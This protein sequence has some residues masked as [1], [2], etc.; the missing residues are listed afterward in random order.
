MRVRGLGVL[1]GNQPTAE[2]MQ[3]T[4]GKRDLSGWPLPI[5]PARTLPVTA[6]FTATPSSHFSPLTHHHLQFSF[7]SYRHP[8]VPASYIPLQSPPLPRFRLQCLKSSSS[9]STRTSQ[10]TPISTPSTRTVTS[11]L[12]ASINSSPSSTQIPPSLPLRFRRPL[13]RTP[14][15]LSPSSAQ[16]PSSVVHPQ[17]LLRIP[18]LLTT[19]PSPTTPALYTVPAQV[20]DLPPLPT[21]PSTLISTSPR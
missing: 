7:L 17:P 10:S 8:L 12:Q 19:T 18:T 16:S 5:R 3:G 2:L 6:H 20:S 21:C 13:L 14:L 11:S 4:R 9:S 1:C 15:P